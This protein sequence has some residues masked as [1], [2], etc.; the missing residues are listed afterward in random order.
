M[1]TGVL[2]LPEWQ[3]LQFPLSMP[4]GF[5]VGELACPLW[6]ARLVPGHAGLAPLAAAREL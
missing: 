6:I 1:K 3:A 2:E 4:G 5:A